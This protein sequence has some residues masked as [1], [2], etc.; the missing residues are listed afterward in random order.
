L[1]EVWSYVS[2]G[3]LLTGLW[4]AI[5]IAVLSMAAA[6][7]LGVVLAGLRVSRWPPLR[8]FAGTYI[9][10]VRGTPLLLQLV[11]LYTLLPLAGMILSPFNTAV[12][13]FALNEAAF[14]AEIIRGGLLSV[15]RNQT[16]AAA[17]IG[18]GSLGTARHVVLP[19]AM[20]AII[21]AL[22]NEFI[23]LLKATSL[24]SVI[25]VNELML[26]SQQVVAE[27]FRFVPVFTAAALLYLAMTSVIAGIQALLEKRFDPHRETHRE[28]SPFT[29][30][31]G[32]QPRSIGNRSAEIK[33]AL[34]REGVIPPADGTP[35]LTCQGV[36]KSHKAREVLRGVDLSVRAGEVLVIMGPSGSGKSTLLRLINHLEHLD[37]GDVRVAG[38][39]VGYEEVN[40]KLRPVRRLAAAR[41]EA[42]I[43]MVFQQFN[44]F[45]HLS[46]LDNVALGPM[47]VYGES[48]EASEARAKVLL[49][50]VGLGEHMH[51]RPAHLSGGGQQRV[52]IARALA[53]RPRLMLFDEPTSALDPE[54]V[55]GIL[56]LIRGLAEAGMTMVVVTH[57]LQFAREVADRVVFMDDGLVVE[58][59]TPATVL[60]HPAEARTRQFL[61]LVQRDGPR[62]DRRPRG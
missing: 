39:R 13:G 51:H 26:R 14:S 47:R 1:G 25:A 10:F 15:G 48:R 55:S 24:A 42:R 6:L 45:E 62:S 44:L 8:V 32:G 22:G 29:A 43:G 60:D 38:K 18:M 19:Q 2:D 28:R 61:Q 54:L 21:P 23:N 46:A 7:V 31:A 57:E 41:A 35:F 52:A 9:W 33:E 3:Y 5:R 16:D 56:A 34:R 11:A 53:I 40:G 20:P 50:A 59:G 27:N 12:L 4:I 36:R 30:V 58:E 17:S 49:D 37:G